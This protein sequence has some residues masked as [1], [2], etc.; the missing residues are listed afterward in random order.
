MK[1]LATLGGEAVA[2]MTERLAMEGVASQTRAVT[3]EGG[4]VMTEILVEESQYESACDVVD[5]WL[6][7]EARKAHRVCPKC[8]SPH[9]ERIPHESVEVLYKCKECG[10][11]ILPKR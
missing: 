5:A 9:L 10:C 3:D 6:D 11:E 7:D 1:T 4:I 2:A 8:K